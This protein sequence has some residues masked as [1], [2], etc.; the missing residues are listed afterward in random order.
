MWSRPMKHKKRDISKIPWTPF[1]EMQVPT[2]GLGAAHDPDRIYRNSR[3]Q[4]SVWYEE[5][6]QMGK[7]IH[8]S[9]KD[10]D[11]TARH[12][13]RDYQR[14]KNELCGPETEGIEL[15]PAE[16]RLVDTC[17]QFHMYVL[18]HRL[19]FGFSERL[20]ADGKSR[21]MPNAVQR[22]FEVRP[23]DCLSGDELDARFNA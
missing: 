23:D 13:F 2:T 19:P 5:N 14:I 1:V 18:P 12:D 17:N 6:D 11:K 20:I 8:L 9:I 3:Y 15:Y 22:P 21:S 7:Y 4:V 16:S 10:I